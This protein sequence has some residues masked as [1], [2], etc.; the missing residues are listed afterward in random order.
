M[1][2]L[3]IIGGILLFFA[4]LMLV[5]IGIFFS[6]YGGAPV[7][8][9][10]IGFIKLTFDIKEMK[11]D[12]EEVDDAEIEELKK[13]HKKKKKKKKAPKEKPPSPALMDTLRV[14]KAG[15]LRFYEKYKKYA[16]LERYII[17]I[18]V[19]TE[20]PAL[21]GVLYG[22]VAALAGSLHAWAVSVKKRSRKAE[23]LYTE[24]RP[25]FLAEKTD[26]AAEIGFSLRIWHIL[27]CAM[28][29]LFT[30]RKYKKLPPKP[31]K[32]KTKG[33]TEDDQRQA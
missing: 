18:S 3:Y 8:T 5:K 24:V 26:A 33:D 14:F 15:V 7:F 9:V 29:L 17:K 30:Y 22:G 10:K 4:L 21:T 2:A 6:Y 11:K 27:S 32:D 13:K 20:D 1:T 31:K 12:A 23:D 28:T 19:A 25:D 16:K